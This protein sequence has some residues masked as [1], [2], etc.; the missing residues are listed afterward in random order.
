[1]RLPVH[2]TF[3]SNLSPADRLFNKGI[4]YLY[5]L[6]AAAFITIYLFRG[7]SS[8]F[9]GYTLLLVLLQLGL[10]AASTRCIQS[11]PVRVLLATY[12][13]V[14]SVYAYP[15][16]LQY[17]AL[18]ETVWMAYGAGTSVGNIIITSQM[19]N[20]GLMYQ[21]GGFIGI[22][23]GFL[24]ASCMI[25]CKAGKEVAP[26]P[27]VKPI[28]LIVLFAIFACIRNDM[29]QEKAWEILG[30]GLPLLHFRGLIEVIF[31]LDI[32]FFMMLALLYHQSNGLQK[33]FALF[34][35]LTMAFLVF[36][37]IGGS[38]GG[39]IL[40]VFY[41]AF[42]MLASGSQQ[43]PV[44]KIIGYA[45][46]VIALSVVTFTFATQIR[47]VNLSEKHMAYPATVS[48]GKEQGQP[49]TPKSAVDTYVASAQGGGGGVY[50]ILNRVGAYIDSSVVTTNLP[51]VE[52][53]KNKFMSVEYAVKSAINISL[54]GV[55][56]DCCL[57]NT[58]FLPPFIF[59]HKDEIVLYMPGYYESTIWTPQGFANLAFDSPFTGVLFL[60]L[61]GWLIGAVYALCTRTSYRLFALPFFIM[62]GIYLF[63]LFQGLDAY[64]VDIQKFGLSTAM[65]VLCLRL[66][67]AMETAFVKR[68]SAL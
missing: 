50:A 40:V 28:S 43:V 5:A 56:F 49:G 19:V 20:K 4:A 29:L 38:R 51:P 7:G 42:I 6:F 12:A 60:S 39:G 3:W 34:F 58:S 65:A 36:K 54:P 16:L 33:N 23:A 35:L 26:F 37:I 27:A 9:D 18:P 1:M 47:A 11:D 21:M 46:S 24:L 52:H 32:L 66:A 55:Y 14:L 57:I 45:I 67:S 2:T 25:K 8:L 62:Y 15:R 17:L 64:L 59:G 61:S 13:L 30:F 31:S 22:L 68:G 41:L 48:A 44:A 53:L 10:I 63:L